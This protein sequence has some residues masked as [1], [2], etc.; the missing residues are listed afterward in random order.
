MRIVVKLQVEGLHYWKGCDI[1]EVDYLKDLHR[2]TFYIRIEKEVTHND[3]DIEIIK[4]KREII[5]LLENEYWDSS[6][7]CIN[8]EG[9]SCEHI[10]QWLQKQFELDLVEVLEDNENGAIIR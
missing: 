8:F 7:N 4:F 2:H 9:M 6:Y 5:T 3:R 10:A 1:K